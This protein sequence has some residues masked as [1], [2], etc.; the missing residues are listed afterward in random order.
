MNMSF[1]K[2]TLLLVSTYLF[3]ACTSSKDPLDKKIDELLFRMTLEEKIGQMNQLNS[4]GTFNDMPE[5]IRN[6]KVGSILNEIDPQTLNEFQR[7][8]VE[9]SRVGIPVIFSRD[10]NK[11]LKK[12]F[13]IPLGQAASWNPGLVEDTGRIT[14]VEATSVG[15]RWT[16]APMIDVSRDARWGRIAESMGEDPYLSAVIGTAMIKG[17]QGKDL[18]D[19]TSLAACAK[20][21]TGYGATEGG[22]D[23]NTTI[24]S[25]EQLRNTYLIP[26]KA[27]SDAGCAT[28]MT[29]FNEINVVPCSVNLF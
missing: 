29:A 4:E 28:F 5:R 15:I 27:A 12:I 13:T 23:Y 21:F 18:S 24:I 9:E 22:R 3:I 19:P 1:K 11:G 17:L 16:F 7:I 26:F 25:D 6:G 8:A 10:I 14:A 2:N 20:H